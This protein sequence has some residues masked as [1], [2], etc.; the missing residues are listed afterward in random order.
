M[1]SE[2]DARILI[3]KLLEA[4][5]WHITNKAQVSTEEAVSDGRADYL[6]KDSRTRPLAVLEAKRFAVDPYTAKEQAKAYALSLGAPFVLLSNGH[7]HYYWDYA[8]GDARAIMGFPSQA[9]LE[10]R[11]N[12]KLHRKGDIK[13]LKMLEEMDHEQQ[14]ARNVNYRSLFGKYQDGSEELD[15]DPLRWSVLT[16]NPDNEAMLRTLRDTLPLLAR[17]PNL[18]Q[19]ARAIFRNAAIVIPNGILFGDT[20]SHITVKERLLKELADSLTN[21]FGRGFSRSNLQ[22]MRKFYLIY[23]DRLPEKC[24]MPSGKL[25]GRGKSQTPSGELTADAQSLAIWQAPSAKSS[26]PF[27]LSWSQY[28]FLIS[29][30]N[31]DERSFYE[32]EAITN[33]WTLPELKRQFS[34]GL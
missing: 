30:E 18:S 15:Y 7:E 19:G 20:G 21:E 14:E 17:H 11:A 33:G 22:N 32:I 1:T 26:P 29:I 23:S 16:S 12:I 8:D 9:D 25:A 5:G 6:L 2:A 13:F 24:Q 10:R 31:L 28:V 3:D 34:S 4:A 27:K